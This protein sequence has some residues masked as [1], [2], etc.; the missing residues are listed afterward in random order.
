MPYTIVHREEEDGHVWAVATATCHLDH[1]EDA[2]VQATVALVRKSYGETEI[3]ED[4]AAV[5]ATEIAEGMFDTTHLLAAIRM[6]MPDPA[7]EGD[8]PPA[9]TTYRSQSA[10]MVAKE[11]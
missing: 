6:G 5:M 2:L 4:A 1:T 8:K 10:E 7:A 9:L 11:R 3:L